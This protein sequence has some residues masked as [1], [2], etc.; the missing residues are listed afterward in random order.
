MFVQKYEKMQLKHQIDFQHTF[1]FIHF[2]ESII[3]AARF[4]VEYVLI[5]TNLY[6]LHPIKRINII[7]RSNY[8]LQL[9]KC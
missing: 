2:V 5:Q 6:S 4:R 9:S 3:S 7:D 8:A 1:I